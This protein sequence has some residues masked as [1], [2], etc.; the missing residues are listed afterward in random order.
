MSKFEKRKKKKIVDIDCDWKR[1]L[2]GVAQVCVFILFYFISFLF[3]FVFFFYPFSFGFLA[4]GGWFYILDISMDS[5]S[6]GIMSFSHQFL[7]EGII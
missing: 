2:G 6:F 5:S 3:V 7:V 4:K 1:T